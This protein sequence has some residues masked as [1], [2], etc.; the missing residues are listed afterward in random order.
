MPPRDGRGWHPVMERV[1]QELLSWIDSFLGRPHFP[2]MGVVIESLDQ[3]HHLFT[4]PNKFL[5]AVGHKGSDK[6][7]D[8]QQINKFW[9]TYC[10]G[11]EN[12]SP[13]KIFP[14]A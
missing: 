12:I 13:L 5:A 4:Y 1:S 6:R 8:L 14:N 11:S 7:E 3:A 2:L 9:I 10:R